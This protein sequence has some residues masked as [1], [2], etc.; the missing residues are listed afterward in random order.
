M[1][2]FDEFDDNVNDEILAQ[3]DAIEAKHTNASPEA[4]DEF[5]EENAPW[6]VEADASECSAKVLLGGRS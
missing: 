5:A 1:D 2:E 3:L 4:D 6:E